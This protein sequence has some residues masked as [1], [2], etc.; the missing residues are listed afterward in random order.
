M[1]KSKY[2]AITRIHTEADTALELLER[3]LVDGYA[4][5]DEARMHGEDVTAWEDFWI[6]LLHQYESLHDELP[7]AA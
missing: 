1:G 2:R 6:D 5:I 7:Q 3:R 4:R